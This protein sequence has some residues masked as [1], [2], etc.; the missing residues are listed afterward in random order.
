M[1][2]VRILSLAI[3]LN[4][5]NFVTYCNSS[6]PK[7]YFFSN[8]ITAQTIHLFSKRPNLLRQRTISE[9]TIF[10]VLNLRIYPILQAYL[11]IIKTE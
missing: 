10:T 8:N 9:W 3:C 11:N 2:L 1:G 4:D 5:L 7:T 6:A